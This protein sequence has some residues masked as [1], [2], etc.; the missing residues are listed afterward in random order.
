M[1]QL[2]RFLVPV[3]ALLAV[4]IGLHADPLRVFIR[5]GVKTHGPNQHDHPRFLGDWTKLLGERGVT[6]NGGMEFPT[7]AQLAATDVLVIFAADGMKIV[8]DERTRFEKYL[9]RGGGVVVLHDGVVSADQHEWCKRIIG[10]AWRW[11]GEKKTQ[12]HE[13]QVGI[14]FVNPENPIVKGVS[15]FD[16]NDEIYNQLDMADDVTVLA[17]SFIDVFNIWPQ[18]WTYE[19][20][21]EGG[22]TP[23]RAFVSIPGHIYDVFNTPHYR[24]M[25]LRGIAWAGKRANT[26]EFCKPEELASIT[27]PEGGPKRASDAVKTLQLHP[28]F[29]VTLAADENVSEKIMSLDWDEKGRLWVVETPEYPGGRDVNKND[30][31]AYWDRARDAKDFPVGGK[32]PR[33]PKDRISIL[34]D[35]NGDGVMDKKTVFADGLE[36]PTSLVFW[37][38]GVIISQAPDILWV[39]DTDRDGKAD[40]IETL[41]T[42]WGTFDTHAVIS[43]FRWGQDGW[44]YGAVGYTRGKVKSGDG[45]KDFGDIAAGIYRFKPD[46]S[47]LE[48][49]AAGGCNTW[50]CEVAPDGE[51]IF[52]TATC[53]EPICHVVIPEKILA[54]GQVGGMKSFLSIIDENKI[55]PAFDEKRQPYVQIDWVGAWTAAAGATIYDGGAWPAKWLPAERYSFFM[56]EAT[57]QLF[58]HEFLES[59]GATYQG[60]K[61]DGRRQTEFLASTDYWFRPI[62]SRVGPDGAIYMVD[63]YNQIATHNDT[64]G[65]AHGAR[66]AAT[67]P[68]RDHHFTRLWRIQHK[69]A[70]ALPASGI[71]R[72]DAATLI[73]ALNHPNGWVRNTA[74]R[75]LIENPSMLESVIGDLGQIIS[76]TQATPAAR[77]QALWLY[78]VAAE[79]GQVPWSEQVAQAA[80]SDKSAWVRKNAIRVAAELS[81]KP[82]S[83]KSDDGSDPVKA[84]EKAVI[85]RLND[86]DGRVKIYSLMA[87]GTLPPTRALADAVVAAWP[88]LKDKWLESAAVG[89]AE[90]DPLLFIEASFASK[91]PAFLA[92][93]V[94][95]LSRLVANRKDAALAARL[96][97]LVSKQAPGT[98]GLKAAVLESLAS[99]L[100]ASVVPPAD[101]ATIAAL[102]ELLA[103]GR[104]AGSVLPLVARWNASEALASELKP[105]IARAATQLSDVLVSDET[106]GQ[107]AANLIGVRN[108]D[109]S[110]IGT[111]ASLIGSQA[112]PALQKRV[113]ESLGS[114]PE[115]AQALVT[116]FPKLPSA[117]IE[118]AF[119]QILKRPESTA[120]FLE[121]LAKKDVDINVLGPARVHRLRTHGDPKIAAR[122]TAVIDE[123][124]GPEA[125]EKEAIIA[126]LRP[127]IEK[128]GD[129]E[130]GKKVFTANCAGCHIFKGEGRN[131]APNLTGMGAHGAADLLI[132]IVDP[133]RLV[134]PNFISVS[135]ETKG[136]DQFDGVIDRENA[137]EVVLR[138]ATTD[139]TIRVAD[140]A[141]RRSTGRSLMPEGFEALGAPALRDL[142]SYICADENKYRILD[143]AGAFTANSGR[144]LYTTPEQ[145]DDTVTFRSYGMKRVEDIPFDI[146]SPDKA[147]AN[148]IVLKGGAPESY[149]R[150]TLPKR[151]EVKV[152]VAAAKLHFVGAVAGWGYPA[153]SDKVPTVKMTAMFEGGATQEIILKNGVEIADYRG[154][155]DVPGSKGLPSWTKGPGQIRW[156][157]KNITKPGVIEKLVI[158][159]YD[160]HVAPTFF[161]ITAELGA[162]AGP[163]K[164]EAA[165][166]LPTLKWNAGIKT[167][168]I[169][170]GA[171]HDYERWFNVADVAML[172]GSGKISANYLEPQDVS[173]E[174]VKAADVLLIS[175]N[176]AFPD[177]AVRDAIMAHAAAGKGL[178]LL[179]PG[180]WYNW[181]DWSVFN[182]ELAG[183]GSRGHDRYGEFEVTV[184]GGTHALL[185]GVP[186][187]FKLSDELYYFEPDASGTPIKVLATAHSNSKNKDFPQVFVVEHPK[188]RIVGI[189]LGHD[190]I[191]HSLG[192]YKQLLK[193]AVFWTAKK[194]ELITAAQ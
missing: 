183:G 175:A 105:A 172:N 15:N 144:G 9:A 83:L 27:Y 56:G 63:F 21:L 51:V 100:D 194:D 173:V 187:S 93:Y 149:S 88:G 141:N 52:T 139:H 107:I 60:R 35:T 140:I 192:A 20:T 118:T 171:S 167:L 168:L 14:Y 36:L 96:V 17:Q 39:R 154:R 135:I 78:R 153:V 16:W 95:H 184:T 70:K 44:I 103:S 185:T 129:V 57:R 33:K 11:D 87:V 169:G 25:L 113:I 6:A 127:E 178:V 137:A 133:N 186:A 132:H 75:L 18:M 79:N 110:V 40:K 182:K 155:P 126:K 99:S 29:N 188:T 121:A 42:G 91:D 150:R 58:H 22:N 131:L 31:K 64:R 124:K 179:H 92:S 164:A 181:Q 7:E 10:G 190:G 28:E 189:T 166:V 158:E 13:G 43:N 76:D 147:V 157:S 138:D 159:S 81:T 50:G 32:E 114:A 12:W 165:P 84:T 170:G 45:S 176:K 119:A 177:S 19:K 106:R 23:Y 46:G 73:N 180:L 116:G 112:S 156:F 102:K 74:N 161:A 89:A 34:E 86:P 104:T 108:V 53:G 134:E 37:K 152:G 80:F 109:P 160:N 77:V 47:M 123:L 61:E 163:E 162:P 193:N 67:R 49:I 3:W 48:Q 82:A 143:L 122:A 65:P 174:S 85:E 117:Q 148:V 111:V 71:N 54:R 38:D 97:Q 2:F 94:P 146:I 136:G 130:N 8:G 41:Y 66:N 24:T 191:A 69:E 145:E 62:H 59:K 90:K 125:K 5:A 151:V 55:Y 120:A 30:F 26:D 1:N 68:D 4:T 101:A 128:A 72:D 142:L 98:D 115:G